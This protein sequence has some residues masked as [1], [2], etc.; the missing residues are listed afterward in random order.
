MQ[1]VIGGGRKSIAI[2]MTT[3]N[4]ERFLKEQLSS[5]LAQTYPPS[6]IIICDDCSTDGTV[7]ILRDFSAQYPL[8]QYTVNPSRIGVIENFKQVVSIAKA[9][10][11]ALSDQDDVWKP[12]KLAVLAEKMKEIE[13]G[14][15]P[16]MVFSDLEVIDS[17]RKIL[18]PSFWNELGQDGYQH[19]FNTLLFGNFVTGCT[20]LMN[21][22]MQEHFAAIPSDALMHDAWLGLIAY[23]FGEVGE[24]KEPLVQYRR[25][26]SNLA[27]LS[28]YRK[29]TFPE[30]VMNHLKSLLA[31]NDFLEDQLSLVQK[32]HDRYNGRFTDQQQRLI[33]EFLDLKHRSYLKKTIIFRAAFR[34]Y[35]Y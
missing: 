23:S 8:I 14:N 29:K 10:Y 24:V 25:H 17:N 15:L 1:P 35:R 21:V 9:D 2:A 18:N 31:K 20:I 16:A 26:D 28:T 32:F 12:W 27:Y 33:R 34:P 30:R 3:C 5:I 4:G 13:S 7:G 22:R 6:A 19:C 11:I